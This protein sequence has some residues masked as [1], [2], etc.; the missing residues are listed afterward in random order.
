MISSHKEKLITIFFNEISLLF[1]LRS[2][3]GV[4]S[5]T[6]DYFRSSAKE[7]IA[8]RGA[9]DAL[10]AALALISGSTKITSR[11]MLSSKEVRPRATNKC[12]F[13]VVDIFFHVFIQ[14]NKKSISIQ[15]NE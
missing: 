7:L 4:Q 6:L 1:F 9:E 11:S 10:A 3:E 5:E 2:I 8:E 15:C 14:V 13:T 12:L